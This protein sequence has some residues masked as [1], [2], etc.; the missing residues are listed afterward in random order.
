MAR[1]SGADVAKE[2]A[3]KQ[4]KIAIGL[5]V[6]LVLA[7]GYAVK[8]MMSLNSGGAKPVASDTSTTTVPSTSTT[9]VT[10]TPAVTPTATPTAA[11]SLAAPSFAGTAT[12][13]AVD[14]QSGAPT[15]SGGLVS[16]VVPTAGVGQ[17]QSFS[18][19]TSKD[20]FSKSTAAAA[21]PTK[22]SGT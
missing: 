8:T 20:P 11:P 2:K 22:S 7:M 19:F 10:T 13:P 18:E 1:K 12:T 5:S 4:K 15:T 21:A 9:P 6:F 17:L 16:A 14:P 3:A